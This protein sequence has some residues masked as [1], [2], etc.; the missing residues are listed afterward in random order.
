M[1]LFVEISIIF[2]FR[3]NKNDLSQ[4]FEELVKKTVGLY[5]DPRSKIKKIE[6]QNNLFRISKRVNIP[7]S[8]PCTSSTHNRS[9]IR[10]QPSKI[11]KSSNDSKFVLKFIL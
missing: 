11:E 6:H 1:Y 8:N 2:N 3:N 7:N 4:T 5:I 9:I 10:S